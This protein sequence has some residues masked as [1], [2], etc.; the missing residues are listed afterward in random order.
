MMEPNYKELVENTSDWAWEVDINGIYVYSSPIVHDLLGYS[1][2]EVVGKSP[3]DFMAEKEAKRVEEIFGYY[4]SRAEGFTE[5]ENTHLHKDGREVIVETS[6]V[7][8]FDNNKLTGYRG[9]DRNIT[10][11]KRAERKLQ[12]LLEHQRQ[13]SGDGRERCDQDCPETIAAMMSLR[14]AFKTCESG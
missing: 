10:K 1:S 12:A 13:Q 14:L 4:V 8:I 2:S 9:I 7:A 11:R 5:F 6:A 3:F